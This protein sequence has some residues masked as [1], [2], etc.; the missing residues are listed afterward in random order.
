MRKLSWAFSVVLFLAAL[1][2]G[3]IIGAP[4][5]SQSQDDHDDNGPVV[6]GYAVVTPSSPSVTG[7]IV[8]QTFGLRKSGGPGMQA[9]VVPPPLVTAAVMLVDVSDR[10]AKNLGIA[11]V[12]P[13]NSSVDVTLTVRNSDGTQLATKTI[14]IAT[15][16]QLLQYVTEVFAISSSS[17][18]SSASPLPAEFVGT[19]VITSNAAISVVGLRFRGANFS[20]MPVA[21]VTTSPIPLPAL[22]TGVGGLGASLLAHFAAAGGWASEIVVANTGSTSATFRLD[23]FKQ[24]GTPLTTAINGQNVSSFTNQTIPPGGVMIYAPR[25]RNG[26]DDF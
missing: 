24:D 5:R 9:G 2:F 6:A 17:G 13:N 18:F 21:V 12:N 15:R 4:G 23:F 1:A 14:T 19:L 10:L 22:A 8:T 25:D 26:D 20:T 7:L 3:Q 16:R 11:I